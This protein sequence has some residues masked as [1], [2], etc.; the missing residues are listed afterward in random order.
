MSIAARLMR[1]FATVG[2]WTMAS[3]VLGFLRD[4]AIAATL[5]AGPV[6]EAFFVAFTLPNLFRRFFAEGAFNTAFVP[7]FARR[8]ESE[9]R[10][11]ARA[12]AENAFAWLATVLI[13]LTVV[14]LAAMPW[15]VLAL[16][17]GTA[18]DARF[19]LSVDL[20]RIVFVYVL[21]ISLAALMSGVLNA[22]GRFAAAAAAPVLLNVVLLASLALAASGRADGMVLIG[23]P[24]GGGGDIGRGDL[25]T[26]SLLAVGVVIA[27]IAQLA[28][29]W[30]A[31]GRAGLRL[32]LR[33][34][35][36]SA[37]MKRLLI[38]AAP[39]ALAGGV[40]QVNLV[41]GRQVASYFEGAVAWMWMADRVYQ[42]PLGVIGV[43][44]GVVLLPTLTR[45]LGAG[46]R[47]G[48]ETALARSAE[49]ALLLTLPA[50]A[51]LIAMPALVVEVLF[52][53]GAF[54]ADDSA[55]TGLALAVYAAG[56]PAFVLAKVLQPAFF[57]REDTRTP[58]RYAAISMVVNAAVAL[59]G[60]GA[61]GWL[62]APIGA[63]AAA[64]VNLV[65]LWRGARA[66]DG[67]LIDARLALRL[68]R[69]AGASIVMGLAVWAAATVAAGLDPLM[70]TLALAGIVLGGAALYGTLCL[71]S[72]ALTREDLTSV[73]GRRAPGLG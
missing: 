39:A 41:V 67:R 22:L 28:L 26:G 42:L 10:E 38:V 44:I 54:T 6:A 2:L 70:K 32:R 46:D 59:G 60:A 19:A 9:G 3:R 33:R 20:G 53:R 62:A 61:I 14:A 47:A 15:L 52:E 35:R 68:P 8:L 69:M 50:T 72:G 49:F 25:A 65:L 36:P 7:M 64:V 5:G 66:L 21:F 31:A 73:R 71:A 37:R 58:L 30:I 23:M 12:F 45:A 16:A 29:V 34:P 4:M 27:G 11:E 24:T 57:A 40:M 18:G 17:S 43:A 51:A 48:A 55:A 1:G 63:T 56:L 13:V